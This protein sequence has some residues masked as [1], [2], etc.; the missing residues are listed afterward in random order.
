MPKILVIEDMPDS[1]ELL[2][3]IL[4]RYGHEV[5]LAENGERGLALIEHDPPDLIVLDILLP[6]VN[7]KTFLQRLAAI[8]ADHIPV[9]ACS[10]TAPASIE[11]SVGQGI[12]KGF[13]HKP[14]RV[15]TLMA[16]VDQQFPSA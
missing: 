3:K 4:R 8:K 1:A 9:I 5:L 11:Q 13:V 2:E 7:A 15:S 6:D 10:A 12:F 14:F 16:V